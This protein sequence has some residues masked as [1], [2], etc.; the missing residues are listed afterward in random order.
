MN[1]GKD[2]SVF[3]K[4]TQRWKENQPLNINELKDMLPKF[5]EIEENPQTFP[6]NYVIVWG[7][8]Q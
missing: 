8:D 2:E 5:R 3:S 7:Q 4:G 1:S 6:G